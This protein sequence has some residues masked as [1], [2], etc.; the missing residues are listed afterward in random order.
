MCFMNFNFSQTLVNS[1]CNISVA[2]LFGMFE[3]KLKNNVFVSFTKF[4]SLSVYV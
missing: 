1:A 2:F 4:P 3:T